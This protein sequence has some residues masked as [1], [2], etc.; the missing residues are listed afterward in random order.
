MCLYEEQTP[1]DIE[2]VESALSSVPGD[3]R[4]FSLN[5]EHVLAADPDE[6]GTV[7]LSLVNGEQPW[8]ADDG[9]YG[10][11]LKLLRLFHRYGIHWVRARYEIHMIEDG[12]WKYEIDF[13][14]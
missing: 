12:K 9:L 8:P 2:I 7:R 4:R 6:M 11:A 5:L 13:Q 3:W 14:Y 10:A 1:I